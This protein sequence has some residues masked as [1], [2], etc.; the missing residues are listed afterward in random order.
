[1]NN[2]LGQSLIALHVQN[3]SGWRSLWACT[4]PRP[5]TL[6][7]SP[8]ALNQQLLYLYPEFCR[9]LHILYCALIEEVVLLAALIRSHGCIIVPSG[10]NVVRMV[11]AGTNSVMHSRER[12]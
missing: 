1:M 11:E 12:N 3:S 2:A 10:L 4:F 9:G 7:P 6:D 5:Y 8:S